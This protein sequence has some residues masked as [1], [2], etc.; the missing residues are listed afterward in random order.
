MKETKWCPRGEHEVR[1]SG[2]APSMWNRTRKG[3]WCRKCRAEWQWYRD[4][5]LPDPKRK[6][7]TKSE[8]AGCGSDIS[9]RPHHTVHCNV[10]CG[11]RVR[12]RANP[13]R[14]RETARAYYYFLPPGL[15]AQMLAAQN[16][17][18]AICG[19]VPENGGYLDHDHETGRP[20]GILC[21]RCNS[22][23]GMM[24]DNPQFLLNAYNYLLKPPVNFR[25]GGRGV[26][27]G[28]VRPHAEGELRRLRSA[29][30]RE[31][32]APSRHRRAA[33]TWNQSSTAR[34]SR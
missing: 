32:A 34:R 2:W 14:Y 18:C 11:R 31:R 19:I 9:N 8:C 20:R 7:G 6:T 5:G 24:D 29:P 17:R 4:R 16:G 30:L 1:R 10:E 12:R 15:F 23:I 33:G 21:L 3:A 22:A 13:E 26:R 25:A 27:R 28:Q